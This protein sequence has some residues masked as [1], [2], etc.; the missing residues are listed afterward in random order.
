MTLDI[1]L[2]NGIGKKTAERMKQKGIDSIE[3]LASSNVEDLLKISG[4]GNTTARRYINTAQ[5]YL[6]NIK[7][8]ERRANIIKEEI[9]PVSTSSE[10]ITYVPKTSL[11]EEI[12]L[13]KEELVLEEKSSSNSK[14]ILDVSRL[15]EKS[16]DIV[17]EYH[18][19]I[20]V[21][22]REK[23]TIK[24]ESNKIPLNLEEFL[25]EPE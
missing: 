4:I 21:G 6:E 19:N 1:Q 15:S 13:L 8:K 12:F 10:E 18:D 22:E 25:G 17:Q 14:E 24:K 20:K 3:R 11:L 7:G 5:N 9:R 2:V 23:N 16:L